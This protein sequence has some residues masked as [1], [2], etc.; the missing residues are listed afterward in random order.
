MKLVI[1]TP[2][3]PPEPGGPATYA[4]TLEEELPKRGW[5]VEVVKFADVRALPK[6]R[7]HLAYARLVY[8]AA[9]RADAVLALD[10]VSVGLPAMLA[11]LFARRP[12]F[13]KVGGDYAWEQGTQRFGVT[14]DLDDFVRTPQTVP[15]RFLQWVQGMV[16]RHA[17]RVIAPSAYLKGIVETWGVPESRIAVVYNAAPTIDPTAKAAE[18]AARPYLMT[19]ARLVPWKGVGDAIRA[20]GLLKARPRTAALRYVVAGDG[21]EQEKLEALARDLGLAESVIFLGAVPRA[22]AHA[23][24]S[25]ASAFVLPTRYEGLSHTILEAFDA[26]VPVVTTPVGGNPELVEDAQTGLMVMPGDV[27]AIAGAVERVM[28]DDVLAR[29]MTHNAREKA[30]GMSRARMIDG[31]I[32]ALSA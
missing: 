2:L 22:T 3:Y 8:R 4:R 10:P 26:G 5:S 6:L 15:V 29:Y 14:E 9:R 13:L 27:E 21:P 11:C 16:A 28:S 17:R 18:S 1:A 30:H 12:Y 24:L 31:T 19:I 20:L 25:D 32:A 7:R 23:Y